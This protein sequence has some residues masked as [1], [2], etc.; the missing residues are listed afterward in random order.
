MEGPVTLNM[1]GIDLL[2]LAEAQHLNLELGDLDWA[3]S[4]SQPEVS[5]YTEPCP[6]PEILAVATPAPLSSS[7]KEK[8]LRTALPANWGVHI[9]TLLSKNR[10]EFGENK[11][12]ASA[13]GTASQAKGAQAQSQAVHQAQP[14]KANKQREKNKRAQ[15]RHRDRQKAK[16]EESSV[17]IA[18]LAAELKR[19]QWE[20]SIVEQ[21]AETLKTTLA[22]WTGPSSQS[23]PQHQAGV[24]YAYWPS[25]G[26]IP[27]AV[28]Q[29]TL[30]TDSPELMTAE[31]VKAMSL[32]DH[33]HLWRMLV[34]KLAS[35]LL[36]VQG[37]MDSPA[38]VRLKELMVEHGM[39]LACVAAFNFD[40]LHEL[41]TSNMETGQPAE[42][43]APD[44]WRSVAASAEFTDSQKRQL[45]LVRRHYYQQAGA[46]ASTRCKI[47]PWLQG[48]G[49][50]LG[51][52]PGLAN[53]FVT[54]HAAMRQ[55]QQTM[56]QE[57]NLF[58]SLLGAVW[59]RVRPS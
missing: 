9:L 30:Q 52:C 26:Y 51:T 31:Q 59:R 46:L 42:P 34:F 41:M 49:A 45:L 37:R 20:K 38:G 6:C 12:A 1:F 32:G 13:S 2:P 47:A 23:A 10:D 15:Q 39:R 58:I 50:L 8:S 22:V 40:C 17:Q 35:L 25:S 43:T 4:T 5:G 55:L 29:N 19:T 33:Q 7:S 21:Q 54:S 48:Q 57:Q 18:L 56:V 24:S 28:M 16:E 44:R 36:A 11:S 53:Q 27:Q 14:D 3:G